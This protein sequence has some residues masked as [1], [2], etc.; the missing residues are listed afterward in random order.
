MCPY[1]P[2][3]P[4]STELNIRYLHILPSKLDQKKVLNALKSCSNNV[5]Q[6]G[7]TGLMVDVAI[8]SPTAHALWA[9]QSWL[10]EVKMRPCIFPTSGTIQLQTRTFSL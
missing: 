7:G 9:Q 2:F 1:Y 6:K 10:N 3:L 8:M 4:L 5:L